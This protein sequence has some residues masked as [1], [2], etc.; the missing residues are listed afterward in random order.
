MDHD[1]I[2]G[3]LYLRRTAA[4]REP[5]LKRLGRIEGQVRGLQDMVEKDRYC[6][7]E[8]Q[9]AN[10]IVAAMREVSVMIAGQHVAAGIE[11]AAKNEHGAAVLAEVQAVLR[12]AIKQG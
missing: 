12:S 11:Y 3:R 1:F 10:A 6:L 2:D 5:I 7:D 8:L 4:E 9:Q